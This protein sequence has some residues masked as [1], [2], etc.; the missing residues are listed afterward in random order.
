MRDILVHCHEFDAFTAGPRYAARLASV[1]GAVLTGLYSAPPIPRAP[2]SEVPPALTDEFVDYVHDE[3][4]RAARAGTEFRQR[5]SEIGVRACHW[6]LALGNLPDILNA[7]GNW[8]DLI[9]YEH[10]E[11]VPSICL[12]TIAK[13]VRGGVPCLLV[14]E[15]ANRAPPKWDCV[16]IA[17]NGSS[18]AVRAVHAA[19]PL[20]QRA[21]EI[22]VLAAAALVHDNAILCEPEFSLDRYLRC[23]ASS[24]RV[25]THELAP[26]PPGEAILVGAA[27]VGADLLVMGA[28]GA[29]RPDADEPAGVTR[30]VVEQATLPILLRH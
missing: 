24:A 14:R 2:A 10:R 12:A 11:R 6:Q 30:Y 7:A 25:C 3:V 1:F 4:A 27:G 19:L 18:E 22:H 9:V 17:W 20:L 26:R 8:N 29:T 23:H 28:L 15:S 21:R 5:A 13:M 16:A